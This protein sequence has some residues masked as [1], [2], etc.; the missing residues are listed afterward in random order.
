MFANRATH[1]W[2]P[3]LIVPDSWKAPYEAD[4]Q[5]LR[6]TPADVDRAAGDVRAFIMEI[7]DC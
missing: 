1:T 2:P 6:F 7:D 4:A 5:E 3:E